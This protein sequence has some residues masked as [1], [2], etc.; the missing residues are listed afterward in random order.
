LW[1]GK[2]LPLILD[3]IEGNRYD[4]LPASLRYLCPN[5]DSQLPTRGGANRGR[6]KGVSE[7]GYILRNRDGTSIAAATG[8]AAGS[9]RAIAFGEAVVRKAEKVPGTVSVPNYNL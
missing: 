5:C 2:S 1:N 6:V 9:S 7:N 4:N 8:R 3:H